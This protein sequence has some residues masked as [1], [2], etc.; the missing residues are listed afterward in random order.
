MFESLFELVI[1]LS[2]NLVYCNVA[3]HAD[4]ERGESSLCALRQMVMPE[5][6]IVNTLLC[7]WTVRP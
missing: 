1:C 2:K 7:T 4:I 5:V 6:G 3:Y